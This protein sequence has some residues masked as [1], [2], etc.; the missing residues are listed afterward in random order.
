MQE[1][2]EYMQLYERSGFVST[3]GKA[4]LLISFFLLLLNFQVQYAQENGSQ[5]AK[6]LL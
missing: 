3:D 2:K 4:V 5:P 6:I 1:R